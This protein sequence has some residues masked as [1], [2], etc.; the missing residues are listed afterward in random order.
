ML[1]PCLPLAADE[2]A[3][4]AVC[5]SPGWAGHGPASALLLGTGREGEGQEWQ[6]SRTN[7]CHLHPCPSLLQWPQTLS[8]SHSYHKQTQESSPPPT[9]PSLPS[10]PWDTFC[11][12]ALHVVLKTNIAGLGFGWFFLGGGVGCN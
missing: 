12:A 5:G 1:S 6:L 8:K 11:L 2:G 7:N 9:A 4:M 3:A 10:Q